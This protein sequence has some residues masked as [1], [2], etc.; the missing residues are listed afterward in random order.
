VQ[1][2]S[3]FHNNVAIVRRSQKGMA[4]N[5]ATWE[6][7]GLVSQTSTQRVTIWS[8][9]VESDGEGSSAGLRYEPADMN[10]VIEFYKALKLL[11]ISLDEAKKLMAEPPHSLTKALIDVTFNGLKQ[12]DRVVP[13]QATCPPCGSPV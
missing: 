11:G 12:G 1:S 9:W 4:M 3:N 2:R 13:T 7:T 6:I 10:E 8:L 5:G